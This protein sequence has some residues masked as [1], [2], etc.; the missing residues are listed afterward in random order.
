MDGDDEFWKLDWNTSLWWASPRDKTHLRGVFENLQVSQMTQN[1]LGIYLTVTG[2]AG[3][4]ANFLVLGMFFRTPGRLSP[5]SMVLLNLT[6]SDICILL[7]GFPTHTAAN[8]AGRWLYGDLGCVLYGFFGF[9]FGTAHIGTLSVLSYEQ[10]RT[11]SEMKPDAVPTQKYLDRLH[12]RYVIYVTLIW[13]FAIFWALLPVIGWSRYYYEPYGTACTIDWQ[14]ND[15]KFKSYIIAYF[16]GG[17]VFPFGLMI[18]SYAKIIL[19]KRTYHM[20][21]RRQLAFQS[22]IIASLKQVREED[23]T[24]VRIQF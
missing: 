13:V 1:L 22:D 17:Y 12:R 10:Y 14:R 2:I 18:Y 15:A 24:W 8:F 21:N 23:L 16:F 3:L 19:M 9:L 11:I 6:V 7:L 4:I 5:S 20:L